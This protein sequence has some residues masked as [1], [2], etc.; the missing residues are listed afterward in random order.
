MVV[1]I[2]CK[3]E[4]DPIKMMA[5]KW[6][7]HYISIVQLLKAYRI[8]FQKFAAHAHKGALINENFIPT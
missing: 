1:L 6:P 8:K 5:I 2:T 7:Q 4:E 3:N